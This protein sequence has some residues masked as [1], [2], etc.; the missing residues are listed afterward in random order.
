MNIVSSVRIVPLLTA[1]GEG[2][3]EMKVFEIVADAIAAE[4]VEQLFGLMG[5]GNMD[6]LL[7]LTEVH[8]VRFVAVRHEQGAVGMAD[9]F[10]RA[11]GEVGVAT[12]TCGPGL[13]NT[14]TSLAV[15]RA[16]RS[17]VVLI[18][19]DTP[20]SDPGHLQNTDQEAFG[21]AVAATTIVLRDPARA[22]AAVVEAFAAARAGRGPVLLDLP[23]DVQ[24]IEAPAQVEPEPEAAPTAPPLATDEELELAVRLLEEADEPAIIAGRGALESGAEAAVTA[25]AEALDAPFGTTLQATGLGG[26]HPLSF[27][28][29]GLAGSPGGLR[30]IEDA[31]CI[32]AIGASLHRLTTAFGRALEG[33]PVIRIDTASADPVDGEVWVHGDAKV[34]SAELA[35]RFERRDR[36]GFGRVAEAGYPFTPDHGDGTVDPRSAF[37]ALDRALPQRGRNLVVDAGHFISFVGPLVAVNEPGDWI[38]PTDMGCIGQTVSAAIG[39]ALARPGRR[40][41]VVAGDAGFLMGIA[42]LE[43]AVRLRLPITFFVINDHGWGQEAHV[44]RLKGEAEDLAREP[45]PDLARLASGYGA[46]GLVVA[47]PGDLDGLGAALNALDGP[48]VVDVRVNPDVPNWVIE[49]FGLVG[50]DIRDTAAA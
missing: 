4:G 48:A 12:T 29:A 44:L 1:T 31:D 25:L 30:L 32:V 16:H 49:S 8:G 17:P 50:H 6:L 37:V 36:G 19:G 35:S 47:G 3:W 21:A 40:V 9:G 15:A 5:D 2:K 38:F 11:T 26:S 41:T 10:A 24:G 14:S 42:E 33:K 43:T 46:T 45:V 39:V 7:N 23:M 20:A 34:A 28:N 22:R 13:L 18:A 27:G